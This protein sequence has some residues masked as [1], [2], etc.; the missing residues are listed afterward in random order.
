MN[1]RCKYI[2][3]I[4]KNNPNKLLLKVRAGAKKNSIDGLMEI[5]NKQYLKLSVK[6]QATDGKAN[7]MIVEFLAKE[8][9]VAKS[10]LEIKVGKTSSYKLLVIND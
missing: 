8:L 6:A 9:G 2:N 7:K 10:D 3:E 5:D 4:I 1:Q